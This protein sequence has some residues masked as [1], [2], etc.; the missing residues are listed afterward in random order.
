MTLLVL[1]ERDVESLLDMASCIDVM[2]DVLAALARGELHQ[3]LR[4]MVRPPDTDTLLGLMPAHRGGAR[5]RYAL[6]E[7]VVVP[8]NPARGLDSHQGG[9]LL[10]D[11]ATGELV[12][13]LNASPI[14]ATRTAA[15]SAVATRALARPDARTVA[16]IG[17]GV[18]AR[19]HVTAMRVVLG[20]PDIRIWS[21]TAAHANALAAEL[22]LT[23]VESAEDAVTGADVVCT[24]TAARKPVIERVW[25]RDG[26]HVNAVG[27]ASPEARELD[28]ATVAE[29]S[30]FVDRRESALAEAGDYLIPLRAGQV[31][32]D[33]IRAELGE[34]LIGRHPGRERD[35]ELTVF[36][37]LGIGVEDLAAAELVVE[38]ARARGVG[39]EIDF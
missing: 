36:E 7:I 5:S 28:T 9:V 29:A 20:D 34:V 27:S 37:S 8:Q 26:A 1:G 25:L 14:T 33:H 19:A 30:L 23:A 11:G 18:Q 22:G 38:A 16:I 17:T 39:V 21:R 10:H 24:V 6:K 15:V 3:P 35:D 2:H 31:G 13:L 12:A 4:Q 32:E